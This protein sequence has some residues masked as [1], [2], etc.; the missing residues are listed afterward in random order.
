MNVYLYLQIASA[1]RVSILRGDYVPGQ[2]IPPIRGL[3][4]LDILLMMK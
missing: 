4:H 1:L 3:L 2:Q